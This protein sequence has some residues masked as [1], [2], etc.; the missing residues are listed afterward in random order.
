MMMEQLIKCYFSKNEDTA[1]KEELN[2]NAE[3][4]ALSA[5]LTL[6]EL[7][8]NQKLKIFI[9]QVLKRREAY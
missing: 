9:I 4:L 2:N 7:A 5:Y 3:N 6:F 1:A 8:K